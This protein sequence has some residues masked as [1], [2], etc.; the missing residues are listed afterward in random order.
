MDPQRTQL[1]F[2]IGDSTRTRCKC[3]TF[4]IMN[5]LTKLEW[6]PNLF[7]ETLQTLDTE[8][9]SLHKNNKIKICSIW[10]GTGCV[11]WD[12][13][14]IRIHEG[15]I[16]WKRHL[17]GSATQRGR[18][19]CTVK[20]TKFG[21]CSL[22][23]LSIISCEIAQTNK[24]VTTGWEVNVY[25]HSLMPQPTENSR[26][27]EKSEVH[28]SWESWFCKGLLHSYSLREV[29][30]SVPQNPDSNKNIVVVLKVVKRKKFI[31]D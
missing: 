21:L 5:L 31:T 4:L 14:H 10:A 17:K 9:C 26:G 2:S 11:W 20:V 24:Q 22:P 19:C 27:L 29:I 1:I 25:F 7:I 30:Y 23:Q 12:P 16:F 8:I 15:W 13:A 18:G 3:I 28:E 6:F